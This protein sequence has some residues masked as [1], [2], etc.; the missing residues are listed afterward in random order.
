MHPYVHAALFTIT[1]TWKHPKCPLKD[2]WIKKMGA[3]DYKSAIKKNEIMPSAAKWMQ[4]EIL[5]L[6]EGSQREK[7]KSKIRHR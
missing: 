2:E 6:S 3:M 7:D 4:L 1:K 5:I